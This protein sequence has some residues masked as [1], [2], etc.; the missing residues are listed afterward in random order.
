MEELLKGALKLLVG[1]LDVWFWTNGNQI[2]NYVINKLR[3]LHLKQQN[4]IIPISSLFF[5]LI[6]CH[7][8]HDKKW[9][10]QTPVQTSSGHCLGW[11]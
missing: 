6:T 2:P 11:K 8:H 5:N 1:G 7:Q 10:G 4:N 9:L 3:K